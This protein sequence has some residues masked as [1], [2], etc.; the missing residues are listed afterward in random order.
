MCLLQLSA[1][2]NS[3]LPAGGSASPRAPLALSRPR[4]Q[5]CCPLL[6][7][8]ASLPPTNLYREC[9]KLYHDELV[10]RA[11]DEAYKAEKKV[12]GWGGA[13]LVFYCVFWY[14]L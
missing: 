10:G 13:A 3:G 8:T 14:L 7:C 5:A 6:T 9:S 4:Q 1:L 12:G 2:P 11:K